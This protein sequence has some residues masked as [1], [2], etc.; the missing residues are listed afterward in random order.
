MA[1]NLSDIAAMGGHLATR[2][3]SVVGLGP[4]DL[5]SLYEGI[6]GGGGRVRL[7]G[8]R[9]GPERRPAGGRERGRDG[10]GGRPRRSCGGARPG[11]T[12][13]GH[14]AAGG[15]RRRAAAAAGQAARPP[16]GWPAE[17]G[18]LVAAH[19]RPRPALAAG[20]WPAGRGHRHDRC[21]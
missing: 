18:A 3:V 12:H 1:V 4:D 6:A 16:A 8:G 10:M 5:E 15:V 20:A 9:R 13:L 11:D 19:A 7:P 21:V 17:E 2:V 14:R